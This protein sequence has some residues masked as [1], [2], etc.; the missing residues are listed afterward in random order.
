MPC[1]STAIRQHHYCE[2][3]HAHLSFVDPE[4]QQL[5]EHLVLETGI[6]FKKPQRFLMTESY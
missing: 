6:C 1:D 4:N 3:I 2:I 5:V